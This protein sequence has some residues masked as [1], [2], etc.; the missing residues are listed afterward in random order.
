M[1]TA[2]DEIFRDEWGR[3]L[4]TLI[5][6]LGDFDL[7]EDAAQ[8]AF[9]I[10]ADHW[11]RDG[12]PTNPRAWLIRTARNR[13]TDHI[14]RDRAFA[15]RLGLLVAA[16]EVEMPV[17]TT[18]FPDERLELIFTCCHPA[19]G[20]EA[21]V[22]LTLRTLGGLTTDE[23]ARALLVPERTMAQR[24][25]RAKRKIKAAGIPFRIPPDHLLRER[26]DAVL[27]VVYLI[28]NEGYGG[29]DELAAEAIWLGRALTELLPD[30]P[31]VR[32]LL[33]MMLLHDSRRET[34]FNDGELVLLEDQD[35]S[36]WNT[37]Q[38]AQGRA[39]LDQAIALGGRGPY[40]LQA[41][42]ASL[43]AE[44]PC[45]WAQIAALYGELT[46]LTASPVVELNRAIAVAET[47]G[48]QAG[49]RIVDELGL[50][51][52]RYLHSTRAELLRRHGRTDEARDAYRRARELTEDGAE[53]R[54]LERRLTELANRTGS[55]SDP[56][57]PE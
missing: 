9:V 51:D 22:A 11:P 12:V 47:E 48:P 3:V 33:A 39:E 29:R 49:L 56:A 24:L 19:L 41:A 54:F 1:V 8:E 5:G 28:F 14:R 13:A 44:T 53:R 26:L 10:A 16:Q 17:D 27:T 43:H 57:A 2:L 32:G 31:E 38:I 18:T 52:F 6:V 15:V 20:I 46:R 37:T 50:D 55:G 42:I 36:R 21:Q 4:A 45:D 40:V 35:P 7:A 23:I 25:V 30:D 34:R